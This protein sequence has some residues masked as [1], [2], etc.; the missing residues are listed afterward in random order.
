MNKNLDSALFMKM[1]S[2]PKMIPKVFR[3]KISVLSDSKNHMGLDGT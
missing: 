1:S 2:D 3:S